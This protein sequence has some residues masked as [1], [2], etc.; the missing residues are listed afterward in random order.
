MRVMK[1]ISFAVVLV[2]ISVVAVAQQTPA[3]TS[4]TVK[5]VPI[6]NVPSNSGKAMF[7]SY[8]AVCHGK[9]AK[10]DGPA[11]SAMKTSPADLTLLAQ[12]DG[13]K[14]PAA[15][16]ASV[17]KGTANATIPSHGSQEMPVWGPL[18]SSISQG[19]EAQV[20]QRISN[21]VSYID[22]LQAK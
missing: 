10:G 4:P 11:A 18:F 6:T 21:L 20:Q 8:C 13:G 7:D 17:I 3:Q 5:R 1:F 2:S 16:V 22:T 19:H 14:Y 9:D 12:K 15:H